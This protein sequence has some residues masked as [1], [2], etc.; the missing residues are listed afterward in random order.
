MVTNKAPNK[1]NK[2]CKSGNFR[3][4]FIFVNS[5]K[6]HTSEVK[7]SRQGHDLPIPVIDRVIS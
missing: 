2:Y 6:Q 3:E 1:R 7:N 4:N 5:V